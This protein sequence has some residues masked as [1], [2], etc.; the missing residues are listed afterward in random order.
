MILKSW[1]P[2]IA[3]PGGVQM[4]HRCSDE[5]L[6]SSNADGSAE[7]AKATTLAAQTAV[8]MSSHVDECCFAAIQT[9]CIC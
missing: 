2:S 8:K 3:A 5:C 9:D 1:L 6:L 4:I 7:R